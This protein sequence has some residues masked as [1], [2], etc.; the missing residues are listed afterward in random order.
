MPSSSLASTDLVSWDASYALAGGFSGSAE[1]TNQNLQYGTDLLWT[2]ASISLNTVVT[3]NLV[4]SSAFDGDATWFYGVI[5][6]I[7][8]GCGDASKEFKINVASFYSTLVNK[9]IN[10]HYYDTTAGTV[11]LDVLQVYCGVPVG[12]FSITAAAAPPV[13]AIVQGA[14]VWE[15]CH[16][17]AQCCHCEMFVQVGGMLVIAPWKD[18][19]SVVDLV[20]PVEAVFKVTRQRNTEKGPSRI[21]IRGRA[22]SRYDCG[23]RLISAGPLQEPTKL[24]RNKCYRNGVGEPSSDLVLKNLGGTKADL[25]NAS[26]LLSGD[27]KF[28]TMDSSLI[29]DA[30]V[31]ITTTPTVGPDVAPATDSTTTFKVLS[32]SA[33][34][35]ETKNNTVDLKQ[36]KSHLKVH[37]RVLA[38]LAGVP[39]GVFS[40]SGKDPQLGG[41]AGDRNR[42]EMVINDLALQAEYGI[43]TEEVDNPYIA[44]GVNALFIGI[45]R[46]QEFLMG[47]NSYKLTTP[48]LPALRI[49]QVVTFTVPDTVQTI[50]GRVVNLRIT[51]AADTTEVTMEVAVES[52]EDLAGRTY[53][54]GNLLVYP[55]LCGINQVNWISTGGVYALSGYFGFEAGA[56]VYQPLMLVTGLVFTFTA[57]VKLVSGVGSFTV[58]ESSSGTSVTV[59]ANGTITLVFTPLANTGNLTF[60]ATTGEWFLTTPKL[61]TTVTT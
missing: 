61:I 60:T 42:M 53:V 44:L 22:A 3:S 19:L 9:S 54:S 15:E 20:L 36:H 12:I 24:T 25:T 35:G 18:H 21:R 45:R 41:E 30:S 49:N 33:K 39:P 1:F 38:K 46:V 4:D 8:D 31:I 43:V 50:T 34:T 26:Y 32:R 27:N 7:D 56:I 10:S 59:T 16:R 40:I 58:Q 51:Y 57:E 52:F 55:E 6:S 17:L 28:D 23:P 13:R 2:V 11:L 14:N 5:H 48:Y 29:S 37:D 47:R